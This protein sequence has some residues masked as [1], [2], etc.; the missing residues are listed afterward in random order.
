MP[1]TFNIANF[2]LYDAP[3]NSAI[4][5]N[6]E[7][8]VKV[9]DDGLINLLKI[10]EEQ[11]KRTTSYD[12][13]NN[14]FSD[15]TDEVI[16]FLKNY[17]ILTEKKEVSLNIKKISIIADDDIV[18]KSLL[19]SLREDYSHALSIELYEVQDMPKAEE[20][21]L[22]IVFLASYDRDKIKIINE[23]QQQEDSKLILSYIYNGN[24]YIDA[25]YSPTWGIPCH[26]CHMGYIMSQ[27]F[28]QESDSITYQQM[29]SLLYDEDPKF[30]IS[31]P[32]SGLMKV[33]IVR[34][35]LNKVHRYLNDL[36]V[37]NM[38]PE[39]F[40]NCTV[41]NLK[42]LKIYEDSSLFWEMCDCYE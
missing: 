28:T 38:H 1:L 2:L 36:Q 31:S 30:A 17:F 26:N 21:E 9:T 22:L 10:W 24:Y 4:V 15:D 32:L 16:L 7:S 34:L 25:L 33:N 23:R 35:L 29:V 27:S 6:Q 41:L 14:I 18:K 8:I 19:E 13:L 11:K 20:D 37:T 12:E 39:E 40:T 3:D 5:Q 42:D